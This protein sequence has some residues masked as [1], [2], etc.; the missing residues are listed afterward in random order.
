MRPFDGKKE[1]Y[2]ENRAEIGLEDPRQ[3]SRWA[4]NYYLLG[5]CITASIAIRDLGVYFLG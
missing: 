3:G 5:Y 2:F 4:L 1:N